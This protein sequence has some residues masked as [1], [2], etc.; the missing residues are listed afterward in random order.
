VSEHP[1]DAPQPLRRLL[2]G[3]RPSGR[4]SEARHGS[5]RAGCDARYTHEGRYW[6]RPH[7]Y[8]DPGIRGAISTF[9][10]IGDL[11]PGLTRLRSDLEDGS[12]ARRHG[13]L[14]RRPEL[15]LGYRLLIAER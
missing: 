8:L 7:A 14:M 11:E 9:A 15:D 2:D 10:R 6:R 5:R 12:W 3:L 13:H 1:P 4:R